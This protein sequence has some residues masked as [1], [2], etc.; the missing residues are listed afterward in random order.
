MS[1]F[2]Y[3]LDNSKKNTSP[4]EDHI[5]YNLIQQLPYEAKKLI[6]QLFN[7]FYNTGKY[8]S[9][10]QTYLIILIYLNLTALH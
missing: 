10:W 3:H 1:E 7:N 5:T 8:P 2:E 6:V 9:A 4:G